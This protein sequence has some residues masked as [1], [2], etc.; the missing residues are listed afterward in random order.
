MTTTT[1]NETE[2]L[3]ASEI[4]EIVEMTGAST[5]TVIRCALAEEAN[6]PEYREFDVNILVDRIIDAVEYEIS[7]GRG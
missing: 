2:L 4:A 5:E 7:M 3:D 1:R 6:V